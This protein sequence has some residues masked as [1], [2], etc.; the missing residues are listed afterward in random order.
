M[1]IKMKERRK[2]NYVVF[3]AMLAITIMSVIV[4]RMWLSA[5]R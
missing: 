2:F 4:V 5:N 3:F 1:K